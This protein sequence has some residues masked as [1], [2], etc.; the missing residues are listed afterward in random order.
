MEELRCRQASV[1]VSVSVAVS[2]FETHGSNYGM[3]LDDLRF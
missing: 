3:S 1:I 2:A